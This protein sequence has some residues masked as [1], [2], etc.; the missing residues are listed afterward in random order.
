MSKPIKF[1]ELAPDEMLE[2]Y[3]NLEEFKAGLG[4]RFYERFREITEQIKRGN[5]SF[6]PLDRIRVKEEPF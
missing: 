2:I 1:A 6:Q 3:E 4:D 5:A